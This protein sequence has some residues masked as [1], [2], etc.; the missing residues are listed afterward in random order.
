MPCGSDDF[1]ASSQ[2]SLL[3][4]PS[5]VVELLK[6][7]GSPGRSL[8][9]SFNHRFANWRLESN[10]A[11]VNKT[12]PQ[13]QIHDS[14]AKPQRGWFQISA[15]DLQTP[16][17]ADGCRS[18]PFIPPPPPHLP[19]TPNVFQSPPTSAFVLTAKRGRLRLTNVEVDESVHPFLCFF[20]FLFLPQVKAVVLH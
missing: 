6:T 12:E 18:Q 19:P 14:A 10:H 11:D 1:P 5:T 15:C 4:V 2:E 16:P 8:E 20:R 17:K 13:K 7:P 9:C 3:F